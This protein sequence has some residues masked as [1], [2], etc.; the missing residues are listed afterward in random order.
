[1]ATDTS[2]H[3]EKS[4]TLAE[5][6]QFQEAFELIQ[7]HLQTHPDDPEAL[8]DSAVLLHC[9]HRSGEG[10]EFL[11]R[12]RAI[13]G[14]TPE[15]VWNLAEALLAEARVDEALP[16]LKTMA[17][18]ETINI[19]ILNR[20]AQQLVDCHKLQEATDL[21]NWSLAICP[22]QE[23]L[24]PMIQVI[25]SRKSELAQNVSPSLAGE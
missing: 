24:R 21:L 12:A 15:I 5:A 16:L 14:D 23:L 25:E 4:M 10:I 3:Y 6:G 22:E 7:T 2:N 19:D 8:N 17:D 20:T 1:M 18:N 13:A 11:Q 9:M